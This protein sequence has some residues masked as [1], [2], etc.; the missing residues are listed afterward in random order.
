MK[1]MIRHIEYEFNLKDDVTCFGTDDDFFL[2]SPEYLEECL[3]DYLCE[4]LR[5]I[6]V[7]EHLKIKKIW[8]EEV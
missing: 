5:V 2:D 3:I 4:D 6:D 7:K 1:N 8:Y